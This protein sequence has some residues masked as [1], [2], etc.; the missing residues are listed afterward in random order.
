MQN[1]LEKWLS[2]RFTCC[3]QRAHV[4]I[5]ASEFRVR[6][7]LLDGCLSSPT[8]GLALL[9]ASKK[10]PRP[11][12]YHPPLP[13]LAA[14]TPIFLRRQRGVPSEPPHALRI[15]PSA[16]RADAADTVPFLRKTYLSVVYIF[17]TAFCC[18]CCRYGIYAYVPLLF[19]RFE[20][21]VFVK[22]M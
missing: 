2:E 22:I 16:P 18:S 12:L 11:G 4:R 9:L 5:C 10:H 21:I 14:P 15:P 8:G 6:A 3:P 19:K 1:S 7:P 13:F 17:P 20:L